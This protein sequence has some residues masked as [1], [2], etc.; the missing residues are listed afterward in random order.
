[1][2]RPI[3]AI[4]QPWQLTIRPAL[5]SSGLPN[6]ASRRRNLVGCWSRSNSAVKDGVVETG[7]KL[8]L[9][10]VDISNHYRYFEAGVDILSQ[11]IGERTKLVLIIFGEIWHSRHPSTLM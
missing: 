10:S 2:A 7:A 3:K 11:R 9:K 1:M 8:D 4:I 6:S 5:T